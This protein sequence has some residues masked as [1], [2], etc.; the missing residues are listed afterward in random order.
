MTFYGCDSKDWPVISDFSGLETGLLKHFG[1]FG[2]LF[3]SGLLRR[4]KAL[5]RQRGYTAAEIHP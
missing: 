4:Q 1:V 2:D 5:L 3:S